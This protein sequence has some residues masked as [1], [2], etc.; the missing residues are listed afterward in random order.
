ALH[1]LDQVGHQV[2]PTLILVFYFTP[3]GFDVFVSVDDFVVAAA[4]GTKHRE[5]AK[6]EQHPRFPALHARL[7]KSFP[8]TRKRERY[9][10]VNLSSC[11]ASS[12]S[13]SS[14]SSGSSSSAPSVSSSGS[15]LLPEPPVSEPVS[16]SS[17]PVE[18]PVPVPESDPPLPDP[19]PPPV[20]VPV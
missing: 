16:P 9:L 1:G 3:R 13:S 18:P 2:R 19:G 12:S 10:S 20:P 14:G 5:H 6:A 4:G 17:F 7:H 8:R 15:V 11:S